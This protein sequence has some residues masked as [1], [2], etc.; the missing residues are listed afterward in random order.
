M[1][2][3]RMFP[4]YAVCGAGRLGLVEKLGANPYNPDEWAFLGKKVFPKEGEG[5]RWMSRARNIRFLSE[6]DA[7][8]LDY[9][10][11]KVWMYDDLCK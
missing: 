9:A 8:Q 1:D 11:E 10:L 4:K 3:E 2:E 6:F 5:P 7:D